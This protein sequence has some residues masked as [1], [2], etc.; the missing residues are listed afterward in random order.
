[1]TDTPA[2]PEDQ[3]P[4]DG[5]NN[6]A[7]SPTPET[8]SPSPAP[9]SADPTPSPAP[10]P[11]AEP[12]DWR[13]KLAAGDEKELKR[14]GR[15][16]SEADLYK[17]YRE[18]E[19]KKSSGELKSPFPKDGSDEEKALWRKENS[20]PD[21]PDKYDLTFESGLVIG[22]EDK[23]M[24]DKFVAAMHGQNATNE[25]VKAG[26]SAYYAL[27]EE[28]KAAQAEADVDF[29]D[30]SMESLR[31]EWG[32]DFKKNVNAV[33]G[34]LESAPDSVKEI[35]DAARTADGKIVGNH[36][37][38]VKWLASMAFEINPAA[39]VMPGS[40]NNPSSA[41]ADEIAGFEKMIANRDPAYWGDSKKQA[42]Y[43]EL[44]AAQEKIQ[45]KG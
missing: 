17:A 15:F 2:N 37:D 33:A 27:V 36:P 45:A 38:V 10:A 44:L 24:V 4:Q 42:R 34:L 3:A 7:L 25:Q 30:T 9:A 32:G 22:E 28:Q 11:A 23:P 13:V 31:E 19:K 1:M 14:L 40:I 39:T 26:L 5:N 21:A 16:A 35:F 12:E 8:Q 18:L 29:K 41:I 43:R 20:I 6:P